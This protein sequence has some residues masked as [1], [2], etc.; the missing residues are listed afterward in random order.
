MRV[1]SNI[2]IPPSSYPSSYPSSSILLRRKGRVRGRVKVIKGMRGLDV[3]LDHIEYLKS[4]L[5][6]ILNISVIYLT[7]NRFSAIF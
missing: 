6:M 5:P 1:A 2:L 7:K 4:V 3:S